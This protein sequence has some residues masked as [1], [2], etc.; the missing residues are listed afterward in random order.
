MQ[1]GTI[2]LRA[3]HDGK[4]RKYGR[5][6]TPDHST[7]EVFTMTSKPGYYITAHNIRRARIHYTLRWYRGKN[8]EI[9][10]KK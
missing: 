5:G 4:S 3:S 1:I 10:F 9:K 8:G 2:W 7:E 6:N